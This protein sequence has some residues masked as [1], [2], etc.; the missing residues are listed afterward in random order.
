MVLLTAL[1]GN[2]RWEGQEA[3]WRL[4]TGAPENLGASLTFTPDPLSILG[5][6][7]NANLMFN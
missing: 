2:A 7:L 6:V 4:G 1:A 3:G 5:Q